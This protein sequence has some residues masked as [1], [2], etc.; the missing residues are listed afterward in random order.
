MFRC[1]YKPSYTIKTLVRLIIH[2]YF[3]FFFLNLFPLGYNSKAT[4]EGLHFG[5][6]PARHTQCTACAEQVT[7]LPHLST[8]ITI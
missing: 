2:F 6:E 7:T 8:V 1:F 3:V 4:R 5:G